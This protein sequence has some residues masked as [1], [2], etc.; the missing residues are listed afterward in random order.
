MSTTIWVLKATAIQIDFYLGR[1]LMRKIVTLSMVAGAA[2]LVAACGGTE[3]AAT[4][5]TAVTEMNAADAMEGTT[6]DA[7]TNVD[8]ATNATDAMAADANTTAE[9]NTVDAMN[10]TNAA[11]PAEAK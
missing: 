8:A 9:A 2:L 10:A 5:N 4:E 7:M 11:A 1:I 6:N 3:P